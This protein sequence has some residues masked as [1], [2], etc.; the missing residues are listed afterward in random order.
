MT[1]EERASSL[2]HSEIVKVLLR[3]EELEQEL[4]WFRQQ[5]FGQK[6]E[7]R[8]YLEDP[9]Q[10]SLGELAKAAAAAV[11][12]K[13]PVKGYE[14]GKA[15]KVRAEDAVSD[16][17]L[18]FG[19]D[20]PVEEVVI[21]NPAIIGLSENDYEKL[22]D[23][24]TYRLAQKPAAY[25]V[26]KYV[27]P[28]FK[29][30][31]AQ[32]PVCAKM[33]PAVIKGSFADVSFLAGMLIDKILY[34]LP[35]YRQHQRLNDIGIQV[36]RATLTNLIH[37]LG[38]LLTPVYEEQLKSILQSLVILM[39]ETPMKAGLKERGKMRQ[40]YFWPV[41]GDKD[42]ICFPW[43]ESRAAKHVAEILGGYSGIIETDGYLPYQ[44]FAAKT[45]GIIRAQCWNHA[46][47]EFA[48][49]VKA[50]PDLANRAMDYIAQ[51]YAI[52]DEIKERKLKEVEKL[53]VRKTRSAPVVEEFFTWLEDAFAQQCLI[54]TNLF[55]KAAKY[56]IKRKEALQV[57]LRFPEVP[58][59][60]NPD[61][62]EIRSIAMGRKNWNFC[63][64]EV[65]AKHIGIFQ[66]L[67]RTCLLQ[68][69]NPWHYFVDV[70]QR[71]QTHPVEQ[72]DLLTPRLWKQ[73]LE[74]QRIKT[75]L[76]LATVI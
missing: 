57:F 17:G 45:E 51:L 25:V 71:I 67:M 68:D 63:W 40:A 3:N 66:S 60:T 24:I 62:R 10:M 28:V 18:R 54:P 49:A 2:N 74:S 46:R 69:V 35:L 53:L 59:D 4:A 58:L 6:S 11:P 31:K 14:R 21:P 22:E 48:K 1:V 26:I 32:S 9:R 38:E 52:E 39:D 29:L 44:T 72:M 50:E 5:I 15:P 73:H 8:K 33:P 56:V 64:T 42:E 37:Q 75:P 12:E 70:L 41:Y 7:Q 36:S 55:T 23:K 30:N 20:V 65:G 43:R 13:T 76:E 61:E 19:P 34:H 16:S 27:R 47:R